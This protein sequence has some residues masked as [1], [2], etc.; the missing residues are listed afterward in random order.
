MFLERNAIIFIM[1]GETEPEGIRSK[2]IDHWQGSET[3]QGQPLGWPELKPARF[4][5]LVWQGDLAHVAIT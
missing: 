3:N 1:E 4:Y 2:R 5:L